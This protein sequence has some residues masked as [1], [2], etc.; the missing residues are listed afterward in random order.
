MAFTRYNA[1]FIGVW[2]GAAGIRYGAVSR[3]TIARRSPLDEIS[4]AVCVVAPVTCWE[5]VP[6]LAENYGTSL[7]LSGGPPAAPLRSD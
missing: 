2:P 7:L 4:F 5:E 6:Q 3:P 1:C